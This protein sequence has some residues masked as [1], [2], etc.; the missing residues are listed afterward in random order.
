MNRNACWLGIAIGWSVGGWGW[1]SFA[2]GQIVPDSTLPVNSIVTPQNNT[3]QIDGGT[4]AGGNLFHS[5]QDFSLPTGSEAFFNNAATVENIITRVT[6]SNVSQID[7]LIRANGTANLF[8]LN[9]NGIVFGPHS[10]LDIGGSFVGSTADRVVFTD[11]SFF[12]ATD[13]AVT[14][15]LLTINVPIGLQ[16]GAE[17]GGIRVEGGGS[18]LY[19]PDGQPLQRDLRNEGLQVRPGETLALVGRGIEID[20]GNLTAIGDVSSSPPFLPGG[21]I[22]LGSVE[23]NNT[24]SLTPIPEGWMLGYDLVRDF[25]DIALTQVSSLDV[26]GNPTGTIRVWGRSISVGEGS[27]F[28]ALT[29]DRESAGE[30]NGIFVNASDLLEVTG[31]PKVREPSGTMSTLSSRFQAEVWLNAA[32][33][34][35]DVEITTD[36]LWVG[37]GKAFI[38]SGTR[39]V[40]DGGD[41]TITATDIDLSNGNLLAQ[42]AAEG[43]GNGG[44]ITVNADRLS[45]RDRG[46]I[47]TSTQSAGMGGDITI[48][49]RYVEVITEDKH[50]ASQNETQLFQDTSS[51]RSTVNEP[52]SGAGNGGNIVLEIDVLRILGGSSLSTTTRGNGAAGNIT[53]RASEI[54]IRGDTLIR[55]ARG[56]IGLRPSQIAAQVNQDAMG[57]GGEIHIETDRLLVSEGGRVSATTQ[58]FGNAGTVEIEADTIE[59]IGIGD[60]QHPKTNEY[61]PSRLE[62]L[63]DATLDNNQNLRNP[64]GNGGQII[65]RTDRLLVDEGGI[66]TASTEGFGDAGSVDITA[67]EIV[68][69]GFAFLAPNKPSFSRIEALADATQENP[70]PT[71]DAG[72]IELN[73]E[74]VILED[75]AKI[76]VSSGGSG[77]TGNL[78]ITAS[79]LQLRHGS[80]INAQ[81]SLNRGGNIRL[82]TDTLTALEDSDITANAPKGRGGNITIITQGIFGTEV[83]EGFF[84]TPES[85]ITATGEGNLNGTISIQTPDVDPT[86]GLLQLPETPIDAAAL[87]GKDACSR[88]AGSEFVNS[89]AGGVPPIPSE[90]LREQDGSVELIEFPPDPESSTP[91]PHES[92]DVAAE[93]RRLVEAQGWYVDAQGRVILT[94][95]APTVTPQGIVWGRSSC[96][97]PSSSDRS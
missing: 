67:G 10:R 31:L 36:R 4:A 94:A 9:P 84:D 22:E 33:D 52:Q 86:N 77:T 89:G 51:I 82:R 6:G 79:H 68:V 41:L 25:Q 85:D 3:L 18:G 74:Q 81:A 56:Q 13:T 61:H 97:R 34:G 53:I 90:A 75:G 7:G 39:G 1:L 60:T 30:N 24:V 59:V 93:P 72:Q 20:G 88:G 37:D 57:R 14:L 38:S 70:M 27:A 17:P 62:S 78:S 63:V 83:R 42:S 28:L 80:E 55:N 5:F 49:A 64:L 46:E 45:V 76:S 11:G 16:F 95:N 29:L 23:G 2:H 21:R 69:R 58:G 12:S 43:R 87:I 47:S 26:S 15:P 66:I 19:D 35:G 96:D 91:E 54:E 73:A 48:H 50:N 92:S 40:G 71:G 44:N 32:G 65:L 8:L